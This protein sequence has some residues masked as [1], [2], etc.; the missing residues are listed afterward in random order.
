MIFLISVW[1]ESLIELDLQESQSLQIR[2]ALCTQGL[3]LSYVFQKRR[4]L[5]GLH[6]GPSVC[7]VAGST[8][9]ILSFSCATFY[10]VL[11]S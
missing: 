1:L 5:G 7:K 4:M 8:V 11:H 10:T 3:L 9:H 6:L 2:L